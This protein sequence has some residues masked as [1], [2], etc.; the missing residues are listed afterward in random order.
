MSSNSND[1]KK[2]YV[3]GFNDGKSQVLKLIHLELDKYDGKNSLK[4]MLV[5]SHNVTEKI[6]PEIEV[7]I[8]R[9]NSILKLKAH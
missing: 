5:G 9:I 4:K 2:Q 6:D 3:D 7:I 8:N 1:S